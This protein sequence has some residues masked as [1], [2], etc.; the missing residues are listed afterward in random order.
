MSGPQPRQEMKTK[1]S[2]WDIN[3][4]QLSVETK[5]AV[6]RIPFVNAGNWSDNVK[7]ETPK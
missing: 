4:P 2:P 3:T 7:C 5:G 1:F 6:S